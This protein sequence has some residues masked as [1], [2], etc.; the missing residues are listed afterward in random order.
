MPLTECAHVV[1][2]EASEIAMS[3]YR[4]GNILWG[5]AQCLALIFPLLFLV[6][7][8]SAKLSLVARTYGRKW[9]FGIA[10]YLIVFVILYQILDFP[11]DFYIEYLREHAYGLSNQ[12]LVSWFVDYGKNLL[13]T[14]VSAVAFVWIFYLL[15]RKSPKRWWIYGS[16][17]SIVISFIT[18]F[19]QPI[20][21][22]P[23]FN[24]FT[25][26]Q[27]KQLER[28]I[29]Q[30]ASKA[31]IEHGR[32]FEVNKSK[33]TNLLNAYVTG[34]GRTSRIVLWDTTI[35]KLSKEELLFVMGHEMGHYVLHHMWW[36]ML[37]FSLSS[38]LM[39]YF[40]YRV[41]HIMIHRYRQAWGFQYVYNIA[42]LPLFLFLIT[43]F[44]IVSLP[45]F[46]VVSRHMEHEADRFGLEI[47]QNNK[48]AAEAFIVL[49]QQNLANPR[50]GIIYKIWR[51]SHPPLAERIEFANSY[52]P[53]MN[54]APVDR[55]VP[56]Q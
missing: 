45:V 53:W 7:G 41:A 31:G 6:T 49:Q 37:Y 51:S 28:E 15:L 46:N 38:V 14:I 55:R 42:S 3:Y 11:L 22:D 20:W 32:V 13:V 10:L 48:A 27:D 43:V 52:C 23:L 17:A 54:K 39:F 44:S 56:A 30:L 33:D 24:T 47:T 36:Y 50:P 26:M 34:F 9:F 12:K 8:F 35:K 1:V 19:I 29:L 25:P 40:L 18:M 16:I 5:I 21:I 4:S 2:P